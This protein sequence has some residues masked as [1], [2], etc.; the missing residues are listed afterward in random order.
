MKISIKKSILKSF[1][2]EDAASRSDTLINNSTGFYGNFG[3]VKSF[4]GEEDI[5]EDD[6]ELP[7]KPNSQMAVQLSVDEPP[8]DDPDFI[9]ATIQ[10]LCLAAC[11]IAKEVPFNKIEFFYRKL[12]KLLD[13]A[14]DEKDKELFELNEALDLGDI[15]APVNR[16]LYRQLQIIEQKL[17]EP[18]T[19]MTYDIAADAFMKAAKQAGMNFTRKEVI[20]HFKEVAPDVEQSQEYDDDADVFVNPP[21]NMSDITPERVEKAKTEKRI[22]IEDPVSGMKYDP[23]LTLD[24][25]EG[26]TTQ[27]LA[28]L[29]KDILV[30]LHD[31]KN[32]ETEYKQWIDGWEF[33]D[34]VPLNRIIYNVALQLHEISFEIR[35]A[36]MIK[37]FGGQFVGQVDKE[38]P[39]GIHRYQSS[40]RLSSEFAERELGDIER[41]YGLNYKNCMHQDNI[42]K[43]TDEKLESVLYNAIAGLYKRLPELR[44]KTMT[45]VGK[46]YPNETIESTINFI[47]ELL[48]YKYRGEALV[49]EE[50]IVLYAIRGMFSRALID[51]P[52]PI[53]IPKAPI[54]YGGNKPAFLK[55]AKIYPDL[56][57]KELP[58]LIL[59]MI[60]KFRKGSGVG[61]TIEGNDYKFTH[62]R[63]GLS[64]TVPKEELIKKIE[65]YVN[66]QIDIAVTPKDNSEK[67]LKDTDPEKETIASMQKIDTD[68]DEGKEKLNFEG[69][70]RDEAELKKVL[71]EL[72]K[73]VNSNAWM[74]MAPLFGFSGAPGVRQWFL[75]FPEAKMKISIAARK[76]LPNATKAMEEINFLYDTLIKYFIDDSNIHEGKPGL[77]SLMIKEEEAKK[78]PSDDDKKELKLLKQ[79]H[80]DLHQLAPLINFEDIPDLQGQPRY[81]DLINTPGGKVLKF[82]VGEIFDKILTRN[83]K[84]W[85]KEVIKMLEAEGLS[86]KDAKT[87]S[88]YFTGL[89]KIPDFKNRHKVAL[90]IIAAGITKDK[91]FR[92]YEKSYAWFF[93][94][95]GSLLSST[96][97]NTLRKEIEYFEKE[98]N[99]L[100]KGDKIN[101]SV[102]NKIKGMIKNSIKSYQDDLGVEV[103]AGRIQ[104]MLKQADKDYPH[105]NLFDNKKSESDSENNKEK[106]LTENL[107]KVIKGFISL[108]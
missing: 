47:A 107:V 6:E 23:N 13:E 82:L 21:K 85:E 98:S 62:L 104:A 65:E 94:N 29:D 108:N 76:G 25:I 97:A 2:S 53:K 9:P 7:L 74:H 24:Q 87:Y 58:P 14:L 27:E 95:L 44:H 73:M 105:F 10:E 81:D 64:I 52:D 99:T 43:M 54:G 59:G 77:I 42:L 32:E 17:Q 30:R 79:I 90:K 39:L 102:L 75:K 8:V 12:H 96:K 61:I 70:T 34:D 46:F 88:Q 11:R 106:Q 15:F 86:S 48:S 51:L 38:H 78:N 63:K 92:I 100:Y 4:N 18:D 67:L 16:R 36:N 91:F 69:L 5:D 56:F 3:S 55:R 45:V 49:L 68:A 35:R 84:D 31:L 50:N 33:S 57:K 22:K 41:L 1:L 72:K 71:V 101:K 60:Q 93:N 20:D 28:Q 83:Y 89:K 26:P 37:K 80:H 19:Q 103:A 40:S 66:L